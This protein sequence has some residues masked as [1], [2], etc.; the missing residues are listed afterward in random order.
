MPLNLDPQALIQ[1]LLGLQNQQAQSGQAAIQALQSTNEQ[2]N[3]ANANALQ[4]QRESVAASNQAAQYEIDNTYTQNKLVE[5]LQR[6]LGLNPEDPNNIV[7]HNAAVAQE[8]DREYETARAEYDKLTQADMLTNPLGYIMAQLKMPTVAAR[9]N[10]I[11]D[12]KDRALANIR[13][14]TAA[15]QSAKS[16]VVANLADETARAQTERARAQS[17]AAEAQLAGI[18]AS[19][20][21][22]RAG[23][24]M[25]LYQVESQVA[26]S[27]MSTIG[28][29]S[30]MADRIEARAERAEA[31]KDREEERQ[32]RRLALQEKLTAAKEKQD[33]K[34]RLNQRL[35]VV[36]KMLGR[37][38]PMTVDE[39]GKLTNKEEQMHWVE[40]AQTGQLGPDFRSSLGFY[41]NRGSRAGI[42]Q[43]G[44]KP[45][46]QS[47]QNLQAGVAAFR[48]QAQA[49]LTKANMGK[50]PKD[51]EVVAR[52]FE[53][54]QA[55]IVRAAGSK[56]AIDDLSSRV[57]DTTYNPYKA[58][59]L[60]LNSSVSQGNPKYAALQN[61][62]VKQQ[63]D[64][65]VKAG[66][67]QSDNLT[68]DQQQQVVFSL[69][70]QVKARKLSP[71]VAAAH[72][73]Q[74][75][76]AAMEF[77]KEKTGYTLFALPAQDSYMFTIGGTFGDNNRV[78]VN[79]ADP[80]AVENAIQKH[81]SKQGSGM[82]QMSGL[83]LPWTFGLQRAANEAKE[84]LFPTE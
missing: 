16:T 56:G 1:T 2:T 70:E 14:S 68:S 45:V 40:V 60:A 24:I 47:A 66:V 28:T 12:R 64:T 59:F 78:Q 5:D 18:E 8:S 31:R 61:N 53:L 63:V 34:D 23:Q 13:E 15:L 39:L 48:G 50:A 74:Y 30:A 42:E 32:L 6:Q 41:L 76:K 11:A 33:E 44:G 52:A 71:Q 37:P 81:I 57:W 35:A 84:K 67:V 10:A 25:Q 77:N 75:T 29:V 80:T 73:S 46:Y 9:V 17:L 43:A 19:Q 65:L 55:S 26:N 69:I 36:S 7:A 20:S 49:E 82:Q 38:E 58:N 72:I 62:L 21:A 79:L 51:A 54:Y 4:K 27:A 3:Q 83:V 22:A